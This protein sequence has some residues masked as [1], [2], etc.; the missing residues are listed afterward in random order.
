MN[1]SSAITH[2]FLSAALLT[3]IFA[4]GATAQT[5]NEDNKILVADG[6]TG[7]QFGHAIATYSGLAVAGANTDDD[8]GLNSGSAYIIN[9]A[10][11]GLPVK[12]LANDGNPGDLF[13]FSVDI[14]PGIVGAAGGVLAI[15][16]APNDSDQG[17]NSGSAY[18]FHTSGAQYA[19]LL[20]ND[21][22]LGDNFGVS[23]AID[24]GVAVVGAPEDDD[25][26]ID[27]GS[28]YLFNAVTGSQYAKLTPSN[29]AANDAFGHS[30]AISNGIVAVGALRHENGGVVS[31]AVYLFNAVTG[32]QLAQLTPNDSTQFQQFGYSL[33]IDSNTV[34]VGALGS[35][36][37]FIFDA[38]SFTQLSELTPSTP[39]NGFGWSIGIDGNNVVVGALLDP[40]NGLQSGSGYLFNASTGI[41]LAKL[42]PSDGA[43]LE[44]FGSSIAIDIDLV[45]VG[46]RND[47]D[48][49]QGSGSAY[50]FDI[51]CPADI[52]GDGV[53]N[54][55]D[56]S[57]FL[58]AFNN[59]NPIA[60]FNNDGF[61]N[62]FDISA[63]LAAFAAGCP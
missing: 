33:A 36:S 53:L 11:D 21:G 24:N 45:V 22:A 4:P 15:V 14:G 44:Q 1:H 49:G 60:D 37:A 47:D 38:I 63:F 19:K 62:F 23:V 16:G 52:N 59:Q 34:A 50:L 51:D 12:L 26:G 29:G 10:I 8:N 28:A 42:V 57:A 20:P 27:S 7:D 54:F 30:V 35:A 32:T 18:L 40:I 39:G 61:W 41:E 48:N 25:N 55:F 6:Q 46:A 13:G 5:I 2:R 58:T 9:L 43:Q 56:I 17:A 31:G 3:V